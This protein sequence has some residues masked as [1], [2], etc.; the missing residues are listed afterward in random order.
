MLCDS[1]LGF[2]KVL[3][4]N[5]FFFPH[6]GAE[7]VF[8]QEREMVKNTEGFE[9]IDF[10]MKHEKNLPSEQSEYFVDNVDYNNEHGLKSKLKVSRDFIHNQQACEKFERLIINEKPDIVHFH[11]IYHQLTPSIIKIA[12]KHGCKTIL[13]AH[14]YKVACPGY[15]CLIDGKVFDV[16]N[17]NGS[18]VN[19][20]KYQWHEGSWSKSF[21]MSCEAVFHGLKKS[22][23][24]IDTFV[25]PSAFMKSMIKTRLPNANVQVIVN[26]IDASTT[27]IGEDG[28]YFLYCGRLSPEKGVPTLAQAHSLMKADVPLKVLGNGP[29]KELIEQQYP[30][31]EL[32]GFLQG[33]ELFN[34]IK[35]AKA[36]IVPSEWYENCSMSVI[37]AMSYGKPVIGGNIG[38][39]PEQVVDGETG[40]LF[41]PGNA[42]ELANKLDILAEN[43]ELV[44]S[45]GLKARERMINKYSLEVHKRELIALYH[46][47]AGK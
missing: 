29:V 42:Q 16:K 23:E 6:G 9:V 28:G 25:A 34:I 32:L 5:K 26:G 39:I 7:T 30:N 44:Q 31:V 33:D 35:N 20:F 22:Y 13:T 11:N 21:L 24:N 41:E 14:D 46:S 27:E 1:E 47:L 36:V 8:L 3:F 40:F 18:F 45:M 38:G 37:E 15:G 4:V 10:S 43:P 19:L 17:I 12:K 2:M